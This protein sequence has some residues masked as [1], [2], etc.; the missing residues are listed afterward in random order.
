V[1]NFVTADKSLNPLVLF[2]CCLVWGVVLWVGVGVGGGLWVG[3]VL[4]GGFGLGC[5]FWGVLGFV[6]GGGSRSKQKPRF[7]LRQ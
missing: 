5:C 6:V 3:F 2:W 1:E 7:S 4:V